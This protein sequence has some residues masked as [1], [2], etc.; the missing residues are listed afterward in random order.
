MESKLYWITG[1]SGAGKTTI[2]KLLCSYLRKKK[3]NVVYLDGDYLRE[4][5]GSTKHF[6]LSNRK[7]LAMSY[8]KLCKMLTEQ[9]IDVVIA[10]VSMFHMVREWNRKNISNYNEIYIKVPLNI[11]IN[12]DQKKIYSRALRG[13]INNVMGIDIDVEEPDNPDIIVYNDG[14]R[15]LEV[16]MSQ[17]ISKLNLNYEIN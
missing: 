4:V 16:I 17:V 6:S 10:T 15:S 8:S 5:F 13:E 2:G 7:K 14:S 12:R 9:G 3:R 1:L 11:L